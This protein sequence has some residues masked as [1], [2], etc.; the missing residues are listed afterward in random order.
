MISRVPETKRAV[1]ERAEMMKK[2]RAQIE[3]GIEYNYEENDQRFDMLVTSVKTFWEQEIRKGYMTVAVTVEHGMQKLAIQTI[4][5]MDK[6]QVK[7][8]ADAMCTAIGFATDAASC[9]AQ[10]S[11]VMTDPEL[12]GTELHYP[13]YKPETRIPRPVWEG[14]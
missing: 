7:K 14:R 2:V 8:M 11:K 3:A 1:A 5:A 9:T 10:H 6:L 4:S 12:C 13:S